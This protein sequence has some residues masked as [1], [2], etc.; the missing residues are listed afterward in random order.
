MPATSRHGGNRSC[1]SD[2]QKLTAVLDAPRQVAAGQSFQLSGS[3]SSGYRAREDCSLSIVRYQWMMLFGK[4]NIETY[5]RH[6][7]AALAN[8]GSAPWFDQ[9]L[10]NK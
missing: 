4:I 10:I 7:G 9:V 5:S 3:R 8:F 2:A 6:D 1:R